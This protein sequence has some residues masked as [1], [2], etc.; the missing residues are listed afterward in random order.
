MEQKPHPKIY[1]LK[2]DRSDVSHGR[3]D[4]LVESM[5]ASGAMTIHDIVCVK[6]SGCNTCIHTMEER[7]GCCG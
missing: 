7:R 6:A 5:I 2:L 4:I 1:K 3:R